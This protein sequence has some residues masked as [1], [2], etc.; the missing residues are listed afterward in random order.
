MADELN[1]KFQV[2]YQDK[3]RRGRGG[4]M[5]LMGAQGMMF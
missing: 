2:V 5:G 1:Q 4:G 3:Q